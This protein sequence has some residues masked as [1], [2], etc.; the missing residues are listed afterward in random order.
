M[1]KNKYIQVYLGGGSK[2]KY[3][4]VFKKCEQLFKILSD[5]CSVQFNQKSGVH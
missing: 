4:Q 5:I 3:I 1:S 2:N